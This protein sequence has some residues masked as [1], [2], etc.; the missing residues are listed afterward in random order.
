M[1]TAT[2]SPYLVLDPG[3]VIVDVNEAYLRATGTGRQD[4]VGRYL[5]D[6]FPDNPATP[7]A[8]GV[9]NLHASLR[10][11]L[12]SKE[13]DTMAVLRYDIPVADRSGSSRSGG[14]PRSTPPCSGRT[15]R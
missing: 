14:G 5:F 7:D 8:H 10:R 9:R 2:P 6:A 12:G 3:L 1:F 15:D 4:L 11:V 13:P